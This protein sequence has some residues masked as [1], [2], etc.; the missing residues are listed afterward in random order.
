[1]LVSST[2]CIEVGEG[3][4]HRDADAD[5]DR[6][7]MGRPVLGVDLGE[8][9]GKEAVARH[10]KEDPRLAVLENEQ[11]RGRRDDRAERDDPAAQFIPSR[12]RRGGGSRAAD[13]IERNHPRQHER[14]RH[15]QDRADGERPIIPMGMSRCGLRHSSAA[16]ETASEADVRE[17]DER[18]PV[19]PCPS[20]RCERV[21]VHRLT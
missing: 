6:G 15:V 3:G 16:V 17:E 21:P 13:P 10:R 7:D 9:P 11:D 1:M 2:S 12:E 8:G 4:Q 14:R 5:P 20:V 18:A 19:D